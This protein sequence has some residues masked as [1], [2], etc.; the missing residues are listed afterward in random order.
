MPW[1]GQNEPG[2]RRSR[3]YVS[4][5]RCEDVS[6]GR[7]EDVSVGRCEDVSVGRCEDV[8]V[9]RCEDVSVGRCEDVSVGRCEDVS[10]GRCE[11]V[12]V[13]RCE[14]VSV[15]RCE[16]VSVGRCEDVSV[17]R[18]E[19]VSVGRCED[20]SVGRCED[21]S[22]GRCEDVS[23]GRC[24]DVS[25]GR[26]ED[27]SDLLGA[28]GSVHVYQINGAVRRLFS[29]AD[30]AQSPVTSKHHR[31]NFVGYINNHYPRLLLRIFPLGRV[32]GPNSWFPECS[33][34]GILR[35]DPQ[36]L[37]VPSDAIHPSP[38]WSF[39][40]H[41]HVNNCSHFVVFFHSLH[42]SIPA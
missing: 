35:G 37:H 30:T 31:Q 14:D 27:V 1:P 2:G 42:V 40:W 23:V 12:S 26:C 18:C 11:D 25:V 17:G 9:G 10:V 19:D 38:S 6:V 29:Q 21:V 33:V 5:G 36:F 32:S 8:S 22:V 24:E 7:C 15:G 34:L 16:D 41:Y 4:V 13:G 3:P 28:R 20:V 39:S